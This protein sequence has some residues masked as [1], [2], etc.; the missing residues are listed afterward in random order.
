M[1]LLVQKFGGSSVADAAGLRTC[2]QC[3]LDAQRRGLQVIVVVSAMGDTTDSLLRLARTVSLTNDRRELDQLLATGEQASI[4]LMAMTLQSLGVPAKSL[5]AA[6]AG[7]ATDSIHGRAGIESIAD[8]PILELLSRGIVPV[9]AGFQG[10][11]VAG[12]ATTLGRGGSDTTAVALAAK[13]GA[14][15][16][17]LKDVHGVF[18][19]D[20]RVV[21]GARRLE[22]LTYDEML[23]A[24]SSGAKV[25]HPRAVELAK[26]FN[27]PIRVLHS[28]GPATAGTTLVAEPGPGAGRVVSSV[29]LKRAVARVSL[30]GLIS[31]PG[32][33]SDL[34]APIAAA[35]I[36]IDDIVQDAGDPE[37]PGDTGAHRAA[38]GEPERIN[39]SFTLDALDAEEADSI[40]RG[41]ALAAGAQSIRVDRDLVTVSAVGAGMRGVPGV[42]ARMFA[43]LAD[44][45]VRIETI[46]TSEIRISVV[47]AERDAERAVCCV[48]D[49]FGLGAE[50]IVEVLPLAPTT[51]NAAPL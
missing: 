31:R 41:A 51:F 36:P 7:I 27:V 38:R 47:I 10:V 33:Q 50:P 37:H 40:L 5:T 35:H 48:H 28:R 19:A 4:A 22:T 2:A 26:K 8:A 23:E 24:A 42:A 1:P 11:S 30:R 9:I 20:P 3:V 49:A 39:L 14:A 25:I 6:Q 44:A 29:V 17:I 21:P 15:C 32:V 46:S 18:T 45:G 34:F 16:E 12:D 43:A 13:L